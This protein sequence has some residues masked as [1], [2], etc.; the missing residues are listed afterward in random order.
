MEC[1]SPELAEDCA[2][3]GYIEIRFDTAWAAPM[4]VFEKM[5]EMFPKLSFLCSWENEGESERY[6]IE[7]DAVT[8]NEDT[9]SPVAADGD[10]S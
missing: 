4:P 5:F 6:T 8:S 10:R 1:L 2:S 3:E 7:H 9:V